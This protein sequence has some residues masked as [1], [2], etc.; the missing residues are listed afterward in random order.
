MLGTAKRS[1]QV[2]LAACENCSACNAGKGCGGRLFMLF[3]KKDDSFNLDVPTEHSYK[4]G[5]LLHL[6]CPPNLTMHLA[7]VLYFLPLLIFVALIAAGHYALALPE[8]Q[9]FALALLGSAAYYW[10]LYTFKPLIVWQ[11]LVHL[12]IS[13][14]IN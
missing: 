3:R 10:F 2:K 14:G 7:F 11:K 12:N 4:K 6:H 8:L 13:K 1:I 9:I 5:D